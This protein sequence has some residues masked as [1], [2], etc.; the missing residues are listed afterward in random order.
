MTKQHS[1]L[2][3]MKVAVYSSKDYDEK[4]LTLANEAQAPEHRY[5]CTACMRQHERDSLDLRLYVTDPIGG[6]GGEKGR[7]KEAVP[8]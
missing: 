1:P 8:Q 3:K 7:E 4:F 2:A 5:V 6:G